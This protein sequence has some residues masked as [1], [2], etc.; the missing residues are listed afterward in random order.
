M[1][2]LLH[3]QAA[4]DLIPE[5]VESYFEDVQRTMEIFKNEMWG[6]KSDLTSSVEDVNVLLMEYTNEMALNGKFIQ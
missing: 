5:H 6:L 3:S 4:A 1:C 2:A